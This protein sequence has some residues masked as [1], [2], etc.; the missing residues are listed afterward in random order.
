MAALARPRTGQHGVVV[1]EIGKIATSTHTK[2]WVTFYVATQVIG[3]P[4]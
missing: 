4:R 1:N 3:V 2:G